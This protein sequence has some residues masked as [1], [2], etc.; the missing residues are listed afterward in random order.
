MQRALA[1]A[2]PI[3][4]SLGGSPKAG[5]ACRPG[6]WLDP[7]TGAALAHDAV[8]RAA[9]AQDLVLL[10]ETHDVREHHVWQ[11]STL[12]GLLALRPNLVAGF[13]IF[14][15][16]VQPALDRW[17][18]GELSESALLE[19]T[20][21]HQRRRL[22][23]E[24][25]LPLFRVA[26]LH[27]LPMLALNVD[28]SLVAEV[29]RA[30]WAAIPPDLRQGV[31]DPAPASNAYRERLADHFRA[32]RGQVP[33]GGARFARFVEAQLTWD[34]A[35]AEALARGH[36]RPGTPLVVGLI[37]S[38]HLRHREGVPHQ[39]ADLGIDK[40]AV[41]LPR[42]VREGCQGSVP[43]EADALFILDRRG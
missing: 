19:A 30:G 6:Q 4:L 31:G 33:D 1:L 24:L 32:H 11:L 42:D 12:A 18:A 43:G 26:R 20:G 14:A 39:L 23:P 8:L 25:Y 10:G 9:A 17:S 40:V 38:E 35:M 27:R 5:P 2:L 28:R 22:D 37:G 34:R 41:L 16:R 21:W 13:E 29:G 15:A 7:A 3:L 36:P